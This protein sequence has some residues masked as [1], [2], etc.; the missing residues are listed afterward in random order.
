VQGKGSIDIVDI[1]RMMNKMG[2]KVNKDEAQVLMYS[3]DQ[4]KNNVLSMNE[5]MDLIFSQN[6]TL[7]VDL[8][9]VS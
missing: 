2:I 1:F 9:Q 6:D 3:A 8:S 7:N 5:F 4:D